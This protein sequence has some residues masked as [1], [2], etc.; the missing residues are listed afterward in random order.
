M[1]HLLLLGHKVC[2]RAWQNARNLLTLLQLLLLMLP[3]CLLLVPPLLRSPLWLGLC[4][5]WPCALT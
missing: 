2:L 3:H 4:C 1:C 5:C